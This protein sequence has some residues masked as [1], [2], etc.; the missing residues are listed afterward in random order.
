MREKEIHEQFIADCKR[1]IEENSEQDNH[2][3]ILY[4][5]RGFFNERKSVYKVYKNLDEYIKKGWND[6]ESIDL[7]YGVSPQLWFFD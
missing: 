6:I 1:D 3:I 4:K 2:C 7:S 5:C